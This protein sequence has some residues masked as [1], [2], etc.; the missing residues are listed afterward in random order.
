M[1][2]MVPTGK[3]PVVPAQQLQA[4]GFNVAIY[5]VAGMAVA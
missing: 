4:Y 1:A 2:N 3:S 5:P